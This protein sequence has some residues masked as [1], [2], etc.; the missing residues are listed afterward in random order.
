[1]V[2]GCTPLAHDC[3]ELRHVLNNQPGLRRVLL[4]Q[5]V[6]GVLIGGGELA[7]GL[8]PGL[9]GAGSTDGHTGADVAFLVVLY[10]AHC[11]VPP[12]RP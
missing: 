8:L 10:F 12:C 9:I 1:M 7:Q 3:L 5:L 11:G 4:D 6:Q 2:G